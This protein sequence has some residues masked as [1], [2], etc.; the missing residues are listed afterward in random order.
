MCYYLSLA[1]VQAHVHEAACSF[2]PWYNDRLVTMTC[3]LKHGGDRQG[4]G[5]HKTTRSTLLQRRPR[6]ILVRRAH[7]EI[8]HRAAGV[9][10]LLVPEC[11]SG[12]CAAE[13]PGRP[14]GFTAEQWALA[15]VGC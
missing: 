15:Q 8:P 3:E 5:L 6:G 7:Q 11:D 12:V 4:D 9:T 14:G 10:A 13:Q 1:M 2:H